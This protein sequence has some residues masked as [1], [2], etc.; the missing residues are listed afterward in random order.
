MNLKTRVV[1]LAQVGSLEPCWGWGSRFRATRPWVVCPLCV[2]VDLVHVVKLFE[3]NLFSSAL[4]NWFWGSLKL[5][6]VILGPRVLP[7]ELCS[8]VLWT[9]TGVWLWLILPG[10]GVR[11]QWAS[12]TWAVMVTGMRRHRFIVKDA[13]RVTCL[14]WQVRVEGSEQMPRE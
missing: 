4:K 11:G 9:F 14:L 6:T 1:A 5:F 7:V 2:F 13:P 8:V 12:G 10:R 3:V